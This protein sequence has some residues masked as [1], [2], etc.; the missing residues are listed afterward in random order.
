M[1]I[2]RRFGLQ[3]IN[4]AEIWA[5]ARLIIRRFGLQEVNKED[6]LSLGKSHLNI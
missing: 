1:L 3:E 4:K 6:T 2:I 5:N